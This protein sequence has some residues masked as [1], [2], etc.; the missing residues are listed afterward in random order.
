MSFDVA[1]SSSRTPHATERSDDEFTTASYP[2]QPAPDGAYPQLDAEPE[3]R[4]T[5]RSRRRAR[6]PKWLGWA[7][8]L[9]S[10]IAA[11]LVVA[12]YA[13][14]PANAQLAPAAAL[15]TTALLWT[16]VAVS[17]LAAVTGTVSVIAGWSRVAGAVGIVLGLTANPFVLFTLVSG[18]S[19]LTPY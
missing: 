17:G 13:I 1:G 6:K 9:L 2:H 14:A 5:Y 4:T 12:I 10:A 3:P 11:G 7:A 19:S 18:A 8:I 15:L 16:A